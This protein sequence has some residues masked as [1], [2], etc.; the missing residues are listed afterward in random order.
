VSEH[1]LELVETRVR[2]ELPLEELGNIGWVAEDV[3]GRRSAGGVCL[4]EGIGANGACVGVR[5]VEDNCSPHVSM[6]LEGRDRSDDPTGD[7]G[8]GGGSRDIG[9]RD[10]DGLSVDIRDEEV[11]DAE[12]HRLNSLD[13]LGAG[14]GEVVARGSDSSKSDQGKAQHEAEELKKTHDWMMLCNGND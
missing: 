8:I 10:R 9:G 12:T 2:S 13:G 11:L 4:G 3:G 5:V 1:D 7:G 6:Y 14:G